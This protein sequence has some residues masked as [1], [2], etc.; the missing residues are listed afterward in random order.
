MTEPRQTIAIVATVPF[1]LRVFMRVHIAAL[2]QRY[3]ITLITR[4]PASA[5]EDVLGPHV[6]VL[7]IG[8]SRKISLL[9]DLWCLFVLFRL[10]RTRQF[11][12][13]HSLM[14][15][16]GL[17]AMLAGRLAGV[18]CRLHIFTGQVWATKTGVARLVLKMMDKL[19]AACASHVLADS[20]SQRDFLIA[21]KIVSGV[22]IAVLAHGS[23]C[24]VDTSRFAP[25]LPRRAVLR[26]QLGIAANAVVVIFLGRITPDKGVRDLLR[27]FV[28]V[29]QVLPT[30]HLLVVGP[31]ES[32]MDPELARLAQPFAAHYHRIGYT[33]HPQ[34][35]L[36]SADIFCLP[37][38]REGFGSV[39][40]EAAAMGVPAVASRIIGLVDAVV[41]NKTGLLFE[42]GQVTA[43]T[44]AL[45]LLAKD[46]TLR[47]SMSAAAL[48]RA[49]I[50]FSE[51]IVSRALLDYYQCM[52]SPALSCS[53]HEK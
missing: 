51:D 11:D 22:K 53:P 1:A 48:R 4:G 24:G 42:A 8:F 12:V 23:I 10:F 49:N 47:N 35:Y 26:E 32:G 37:S 36:C 43:L 7:E 30:T 17:L 5:L 14:P 52:I 45:T 33:D 2:A 31:D 16:T 34:D 27:A 19:I 6:T 15:K 18:P 20:V 21:Q 40:I 44:Q 3:E 41:E 46:D 38:Y 39:L 25:N 28:Q 9:R 50:L 13:V 29:Y